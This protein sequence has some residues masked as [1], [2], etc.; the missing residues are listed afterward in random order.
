MHVE[1]FILLNANPLL[2]LI[3]RPFETFWEAPSF[4][5]RATRHSWIF[6]FLMRLLPVI[7]QLCSPRTYNYRRYTLCLRHTHTHSYTL[8]LSHVPAFWFAHIPT[9]THMQ[10]QVDYLYISIRMFILIFLFLPKCSWILYSPCMVKSENK[11]LIVAMVMRII[12]VSEPAKF[13]GFGQPVASHFIV[14]DHNPTVVVLNLPNNT[15][16]NS[17]DKILS[18]LDFKGIVHNLENNGKYRTT[19]PGTLNVVTTSSF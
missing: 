11:L 12:I 6:H 17:P 5:L 7:T 10:I 4:V 2:S 18:W 1:C 19:V 15:L 16:E 13:L 8:H 14:S 9:Y 3:G